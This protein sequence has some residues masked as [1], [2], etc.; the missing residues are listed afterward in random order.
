M[1]STTKRTF[2]RHVSQSKHSL[3]YQLEYWQSC[4]RCFVLA[5]KLRWAFAA[6]TSLEVTQQEVHGGNTEI[7]M[8]DLRMELWL[9]KYNFTM[10]VFSVA[11]KKGIRSLWK[12]IKMS[13]TAY[14]SQYT[15]VQNLT[16]Q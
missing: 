7:L 13:S 10:Y 16:E 12:Y 4:Y 2:S 15:A 5:A 9:V 6:Y 11:A 14:T 8:W 3:P 1:F